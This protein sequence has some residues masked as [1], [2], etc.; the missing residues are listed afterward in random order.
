MNRVVVLLALLTTFV[1]AG[2]AES[3]DT[4]NFEEDPY[5]ILVGEADTAIA[6][7][8][9]PTAIQRLLDA[10]AVDP[11]RET[12]VLVLSNLAM[13]YSY[14]DQDS[15]ALVKL[16]RLIERAPR[17]VTALNNRGHLLLKTGNDIAAYDDF[18]R[19]IGID[20]LN[21]DA[22]YYHGMI[23][24]YGGRR[25]IAETDFEVLRTEAPKSLDTAAA[26]GLL[27]S[28]TGRDLDALPYLRRLVEET[29]S[30]EY[31]SALSGAL[32]HLQR[33]NEASE[34]IA[35]GLRRYSRDPELYYYRAWLN[36]DRYRLDDARSDAKKAIEYGASPNRVNALFAR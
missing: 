27:Y 36:R 25:D 21:L 14:T 28:M 9:Y 33:L 6:D 20:S 11:E 8:D 29:P 10:M 4:L 23:A 2:A 5:V 19:V 22:R 15:L 7:G 26:L 32:L 13:L 30:P 3:A 34:I 17:M 35:E 16:D 18:E 12:N 1:A 31:Y 24:L